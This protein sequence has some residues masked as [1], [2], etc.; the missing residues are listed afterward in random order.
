MEKEQKRPVLFRVIMPFKFNERLARKVL[1]RCRIEEGGCLV[2]Q[3]ATNRP[4]GEHPYGQTWDGQRVETTHRI[5]ASWKA[6]RPLREGE[7]AAH[8]CHNPLCCNHRHLHIASHAENVRE[9]ADAGRLRRTITPA[10]EEGIIM[11]KQEGKSNADLAAIYG[12][13]ERTVRLYLQRWRESRSSAN[14]QAAIV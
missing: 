3:G 7:E 6:G 5:I 2:W 13:T 12:T 14:V 9:S 11:G 8:S 4:L 1:K 10:V